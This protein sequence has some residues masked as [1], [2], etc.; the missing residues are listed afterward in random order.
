M[1]KEKEYNLKNNRNNSFGPLKLPKIIPKFQNTLGNTTDGSQYSSKKTIELK[2]K[3]TIRTIKKKKIFNTIKTDIDLVKNLDIDLKVEQ[4][5]SKQFDTLQLKNRI[6]NNPD[7]KSKRLGTYKRKQLRDEIASDIESKEKVRLLEKEIKNDL[8]EYNIVKRENE[9]LNEHILNLGNII[10]DYN[11]EL[12]A[13][14]NYRKEFFKQF[15]KTEEQ[16][17]LE[18]LNK[19]EKNL[20]KDNEEFI[21]LQKEL[22]NYQIDKNEK[23]QKDLMLRKE[24][25]KENIERTKELLDD[26]QEQKNNLKID[27][28]EIKDKIKENKKNLIKFYHISLYEGLDF[29]YEGLSNVIRAI[30]NLGEDVDINYMPTY[31]DKLLI[32][33]LFEHAKQYMQIINLRHQIELNQEKFVKSLNEW[34]TISDYHFI[35][36][37]SSTS[38]ISDVNLFQTR[39]NHE[40]NYP[41]S[42]KFM[43]NYYNKYAHLIENKE[44]NELNEF[45]KKMSQRQI[46]LPQKFL[47][48][49]KTLEKGKYILQNLQKKMKDLERNEIRRVCREFSINNYGKIYQV[50][51]YI[52]VSAICGDE[53]K[54]EGMIFFNKTEREIIEGKKV[55][56]FFSPLRN[57]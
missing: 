54:D 17:K 3:P 36:E 2:I 1:I 27:I 23:F 28:K 8:N 7:I 35:N 14:D 56:K 55:I 18:I 12:Y 11:L 43:K 9:K 40:E 22:K 37:N 39:L 47:E 13:L 45:K 48:E 44:I 50:C 15:L 53:N 16:K 52:I 57:K 5:A 49:N 30:W 4:I 33:F 29:R 20:Y 31:L 34:K 42:K 24:S 32:S 38:S 26:L 21:F 51:P 25:I 6:D 19:L 46:T 41:K 10:E